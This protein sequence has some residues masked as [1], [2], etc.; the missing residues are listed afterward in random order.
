[1]TSTT[2]GTALHALGLDH[3]KAALVGEN[4]Y[5]WIVAYFAIVNGENVVVPLDPELM[6][7]QL[8]A[9][10]NKT[11]VQFIICSKRSL[12][13]IQKVRSVFIASR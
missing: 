8:T 2:L 5:Y 13:K 7:E 12:D 11:D 1:M 10:I 9:L 6:E 3:G 4:S